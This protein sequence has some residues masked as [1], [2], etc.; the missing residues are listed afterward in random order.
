[1]KEFEK[2]AKRKKKLCSNFV[3]LILIFILALLLKNTF[4][5]YVK[6]REGKKVLE[7]AERNIE[8]LEERAEKLRDDIEYLES[9]VGKED[10]ARSNF[11]VAKEGEE[12]V[13]ILDEKEEEVLEIEKKGVFSNIW[14]SILD[15]VN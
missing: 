1:M 8:D 6:A 3:I 14:Q 5:V 2:K 9:D 15:L 4:D 10:R 7:T 11:L 13:F 12:A